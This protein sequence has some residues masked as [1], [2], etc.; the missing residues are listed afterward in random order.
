MTQQAITQ[1]WNSYLQGNTF[2]GTL[3]GMLLYEGRA[4]QRNAPDGARLL[5]EMMDKGVKW[6]QNLVL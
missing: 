2:A 1:L 5:R 6:A 3:A 4:V